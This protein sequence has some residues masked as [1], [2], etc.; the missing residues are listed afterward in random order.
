MLRMFGLL[1]AGNEG[2]IPYAMENKPGGEDAANEQGGIR[3]KDMQVLWLVAPKGVGTNRAETPAFPVG[4][5]Y[6]TRRPIITP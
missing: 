3:S 4:S 6:K 5:L 1:S 2:L